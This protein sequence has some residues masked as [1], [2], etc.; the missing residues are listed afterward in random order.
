MKQMEKLRIPLVV[1]YIILSVDAALHIPLTRRVHP[2][3]INEELH[4]VDGMLR[5]FNRTSIGGI[6]Q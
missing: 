4:D 2:V 1:L 3:T 6:E 5:V